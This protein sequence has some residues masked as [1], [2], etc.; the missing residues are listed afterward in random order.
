M[1]TYKTHFTN[2]DNNDSYKYFRYGQLDG[3]NEING[4]GRKIYLVCNYTSGYLYAIG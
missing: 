2:M 1:R 3:D 4:I